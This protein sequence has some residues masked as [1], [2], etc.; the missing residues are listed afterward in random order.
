MVR[1][2]PLFFQMQM[3][4]SPVLFEEFLCLQGGSAACTGGGYGLAVAAVLHVAAGEHAWNVGKNL[5]VGLEITI[6]VHI[7]LSGKHFCIRYVPN[8]QE[9]GVRRKV[10]YPAALQIA[11]LQAGNFLLRD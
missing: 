8:S 1:R 4:L 9:H 2:A 3:T 10:P 7:K 11:Q 5:I 6:L